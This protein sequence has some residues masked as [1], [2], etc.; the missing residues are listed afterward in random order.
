MEDAL[1]YARIDALTD[2]RPKKAKCL[3][4]SRPSSRRKSVFTG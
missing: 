4:N 2:A 3:S 1:I